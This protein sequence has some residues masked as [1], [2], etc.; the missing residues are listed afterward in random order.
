LTLTLTLLHT[1]VVRLG[2]T[3]PHSETGNACH[4]VVPG[5][6]SPKPVDFFRIL[7][8]AYRKSPVQDVNGVGTAAPPPDVDLAVIYPFTYETFTPELVR[9][10]AQGGGQGVGGRAGS[11]KERLETMNETFS[12]VIAFLQNS[13]RGFH[14]LPVGHRITYKLC[15]T[16]W[17]TLHTSQLLYLCELISHYLP[18]RSLHS[19]NTNLLTRPASITSNFSSWAFSVS[20]P[21]TWNSLPAH[22]RSIDTLS[23]FKRYIK[24]HL[25]QSAFT[26]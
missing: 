20:A 11:L 7:R 19:S 14:W 1:A 21:S 17:K 6:N 25:F 3:G 16:T 8:L 24:F 22:I 12:K 15:L 23:T 4:Y 2:C 10:G 9:V 18:P 26:V 5:I 13:G